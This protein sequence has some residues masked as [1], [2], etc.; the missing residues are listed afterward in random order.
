MGGLALG[1]GIEALTL[2]GN[3]KAAA[4]RAGQLF[5]EHDE[6]SLKELASL[7][8]DDHSYGVA[9]KQRTADLKQVLSNDLAQQEKL[10][11]CSQKKP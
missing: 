8:G 4:K 2:L 7:W 5:A 11:T 10:N 6:A 1:M 3:D 9:V